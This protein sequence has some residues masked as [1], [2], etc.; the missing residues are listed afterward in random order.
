MSERRASGS[1]GSE[2]SDGLYKWIVGDSFG[3]KHVSRAGSTY[4]SRVH[5]CS[6]LRRGVLVT[7]LV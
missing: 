6:V 7:A 1:L 5:V 2:F 4:T 3:R